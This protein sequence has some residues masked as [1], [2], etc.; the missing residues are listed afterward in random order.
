MPQPNPERSTPHSP[1]VK[2]LEDAGDVSINELSAVNKFRI[3]STLD[4][5][6]VQ[7]PTTK[8][9]CSSRAFLVVVTPRQVRNS[10]DFSEA[11][12]VPYDRDTLLQ[13]AKLLLQNEDYLLARNVFR[14]L[15]DKNVKDS[16]ALKG[17]GACF[18]GLGEV[19]AARKCFQALW[20]Y[21]H[22]EESRYWTGLC[23]IKDGKDDLAIVQL[24]LAQKS[25]RLDKDLQ[26]RIHKEL[27]NCLTRAHQLDEAA[28]NYH[29]ALD[30]KP[31]SPAILI[32]LGT[33]E[34]QRRHLNLAA[35]FFEKALRIDPTNSR[36]ICGSGMVA[37][38]K[39]QLNEAD[40]LFSRALKHDQRNLVAI[41]QKLEIAYRKG[42]Y[43][44]IRQ[45]CQTFLEQTPDNSDIRFVLATVF[46]KESNWSACEAQLDAILGPNPNHEK[47]RNLKR[48]LQANFRAKMPS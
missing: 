38:A 21:F 20:D 41:Y 22:I 13:N 17:L 40:S 45:H 10:S 46:F 19:I 39:D 9:G 15:L 28:V 12:P 35:E 5:L 24:K 11:L 32:N 14:Y 29:K 1:F 26:F 18:L 27:G 31:D 4:K 36:A 6:L 43:S 47:A 44:E 48:E 25:E 37:L 2:M 33:L 7:S 3:V 23:H 16:E 30:L 42:E 8:D 34:I